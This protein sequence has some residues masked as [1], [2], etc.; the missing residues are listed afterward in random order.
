VTC[1]STDSHGNTGSATFTVTVRDSTGPVLALPANITVIATGPFSHDS[2]D[3]EDDGHDEHGSNHSFHG[4]KG[5]YFG[6]Y[7]YR[8]RFYTSHVHGS[9]A[10]YQAG[11]IVSYDTSGNDLVDGVRPVTCAPPSGSYFPVGTTTVNCSASDRS[12][13][14]TTGSFTV[15]V[16]FDIR[17][18]NSPV[19]MTSTNVTKGGSTVPLKFAIVTP[20]GQYVSTPSVVTGYTVTRV[21]AA[22]GASVDISSATYLNTGGGCNRAVEYSSGGHQFVISW[23]TPRTPGYFY[24]VDVNFVGGQ[25]LSATFQTK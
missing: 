24:R 20:S 9:N 8:G 10:N 11:A 12:G 16:R 19:S 1:S 15:T 6:G 5:F 21:S 13:N 22:S 25:K 14:V 17:G 4:R 23:Q 18:F 2:E 3:D 7:W